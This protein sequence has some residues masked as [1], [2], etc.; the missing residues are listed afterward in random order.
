MSKKEKVKSGYVGVKRYK[1]AY[2]FCLVPIILT[3]LYI[4][5]L[6]IDG[7]YSIGDFMIF[8][9]LSMFSLF[10]L[11]V[12]I[13]FTCLWGL[14]GYLCAKARLTIFKSIIVCHAFPILM[15]LAHLF[16]N[17][18]YIETQNETLKEYTYLFGG[19]ACNFISIL[20]TFLYSVLPIN[21]IEPVIDLAF[22]IVAFIIGFALRSQK[23]NKEK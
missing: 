23:V 14:I 7:T 16:F 5:A 1:I 8:S 20:G 3:G 21:I 17:L 22:M 9:P 10:S 11:F 13:L 4:L 12:L 2:L 6:S 15:L 18:L 19:V